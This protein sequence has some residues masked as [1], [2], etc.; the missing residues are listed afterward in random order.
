MATAS[1]L[2]QL[3]FA[4]MERE[5][6]ET[7]PPPLDYTP[8]KKAHTALQIIAHG[9][10]QLRWKDAED[11]GRIIEAKL[12]IIDGKIS[13]DSSITAAIQAWAEEWESF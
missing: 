7:V 9:I 5:I 11:M 1:K 4:R 3:D 10:T 2:P 6:T 13:A 12:K 8:S